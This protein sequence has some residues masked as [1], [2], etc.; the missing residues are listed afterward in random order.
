MWKNECIFRGK[1]TPLDIE[2]P[3]ALEL[4]KNRNKK[5]SDLRNIGAH[6]ET[7]TRPAK[8]EDMVHTLVMAK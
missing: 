3:K 4:L 6:P 2:L 1:E 8:M 5:S 7:E